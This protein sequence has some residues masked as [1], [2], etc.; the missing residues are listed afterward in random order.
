MCREY[1]WSSD[2]KKQSSY[3][4]CDKRN[5]DRFLS[6]DWSPIRDEE[7][8]KKLGICATPNTA[9]QNLKS[10]SRTT[11]NNIYIIFHL[12]SYIHLH[13]IYK[14]KK[15]IDKYFSEYMNYYFLI[16]QGIVK[17]LWYFLHVHFGNVVCEAMKVIKQKKR[18]KIITYCIKHNTHIST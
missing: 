10:A 7:K 1:S 15:Y 5:Y 18:H 8:G 14:C 3:K 4:T 16:A 2:K 9:K 12:I 6:L 11:P 17:N 13:C